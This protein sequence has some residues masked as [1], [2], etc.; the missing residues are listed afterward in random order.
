M[1]PNLCYA[2]IVSKMVFSYIN[3]WGLLLTEWAL[4]YDFWT[5]FAD[6]EIILEY[7]IYNFLQTHHVD[8]TLKP[9]GNGRFHV[10]STWNLRGVFVGMVDEMNG[11]DFGL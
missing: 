4:V 1:I 6:F 2:K 11:M 10:V 5:I 3:C 8:S 9:R 7:V